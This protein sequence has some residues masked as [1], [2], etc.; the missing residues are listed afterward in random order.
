MQSSWDH[1]ASSNHHSRFVIPAISSMSGI[2]RTELF[3]NGEI[4]LSVKEKVSSNAAFKELNDALDRKSGIGSPLASN[5][6][7][8]GSAPSLL[9]SVRMKNTSSIGAR[10]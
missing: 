6:S 7:N 9:V 5:R 4:M 1:I 10:S 2:A 3:T 8:V